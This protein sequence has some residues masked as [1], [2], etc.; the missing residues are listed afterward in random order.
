[1]KTQTAQTAKQDKRLQERTDAFAQQRSKEY[2]QV[3][4]Y[5]RDAV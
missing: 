5:V 3:K 4:S 2:P 1:M